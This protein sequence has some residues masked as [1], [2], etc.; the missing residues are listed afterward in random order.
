MCTDEDAPD[1]LRDETEGPAGD[2]PETA[3]DTQRDA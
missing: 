1:T 3:P 2:P